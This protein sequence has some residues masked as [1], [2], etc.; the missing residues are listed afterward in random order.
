MKRLVTEKLIRWA[1]SAQRKPLLLRGGRQVG[2]TFS[3]KEFG[4]KNFSGK[5]HIVDLE[6]HPEW[7]PI[8]NKNLDPVRIISDLELVLNTK[9]E[10]TED[11]LFLDE[12]Q[13]CP[14]ALLSLRY[15][16][17]DMP[18]L[19]VIA[20]GSLLEFAM[21]EISFPVGRVQSLTMHPMNF[22]EFL[23]AMGKDLLAEKLKEGK[24]EF[25]ETIHEMILGEL[26]HYFFVGGM[27]EA[28]NTFVQSGK[29]R[30]AFEV[31]RDLILT[32]RNDFSKYAKMANT[33]C[34]DSVLISVSRMVG[35][36]VK[37][38]KLSQD[39]SSQ[40]IKKAFDLLC[41]ANIVHKIP[42]VNQVGIP[43]GAFSSRKKF[44]A[45]FLDIGLMQSISGLP[46]DFEYQKNNLL[47]I[48][49]GA[50]AE[51]FVGQ[52]LL[53]RG[54]L[55]LYYWARDSK[56]STA[57]VD[58]LIVRE[59]NIIPIEVKSGPSGRLKSLHLFLN[60]YRDLKTGYVLQENKYSD[61]PEQKLKF[62]PLYSA[63]NFGK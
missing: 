15:F 39:H 41:M 8:F 34:L 35:N 33:N 11:L 18:D 58:Y 43:L 19:H 45:L 60:T 30:S 57:E 36:Q 21:S 27:P 12:I 22:I 9:I 26:K 10:I 61:I 1:G 46:A 53:S 23:S 49:N 25:S 29:L 6:K 5:L 37:Y 51:Q 28:V 50:L 55:D 52:E 4:K 20:A 13:S 44:K 17:E 24:A 47:S 63:Y 14:R 42:S 31:Q 62:L 16:Y 3:V 48:Y 32:L 38:T 7:H 54:N 59:G 40:T 56:S 2:K